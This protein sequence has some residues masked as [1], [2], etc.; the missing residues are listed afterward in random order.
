M[1]SSLD[2]RWLAS[3]AIVLAIVFFVA[4][5]VLVG[6]ALK[7]ARLDLTADGLYTV[8][9]GTKGVLAGIDEPI[10]LRYFRSQRLES[11]ALMH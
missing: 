6:T 2:R 10:R 1:P 5:N 7:R 4:L 8:S 3:A 11:L 9:A